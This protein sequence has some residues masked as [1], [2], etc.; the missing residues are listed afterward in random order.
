VW[1]VDY[2]KLL[3]K[4]QNEVVV[5]ICNVYSRNVPGQTEEVHGISVRM[6]VYQDAQKD[7]ENKHYSACELLQIC[8]QREFLGY[9]G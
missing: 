4:I 6:S 3:G 2:E 9:G 1:W 5:A 8:Q 7:L